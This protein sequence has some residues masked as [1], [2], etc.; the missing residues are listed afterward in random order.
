MEPL[1]ETKSLTKD[2]GSQR[3]IFSLDFTISPGEIVGFVGPNG[4]GKSTTINL[5]A[6]N[7]KPTSGTIKLFGRAVSPESIHAFMPEIG[8]MLSEPTIEN[9]L[10]AHQ[11]FAEAEQLLQKKT[12]WKRLGDLLKLDT[13][14]PV[15]KLSLGNKKKIEI[16]LAL[17]HKPKLVIMDEPTSGIDPLIVT[18]FSALLKEVSERGGAVL[19]SS[20]DLSEVQEVCDRVIMVK[21]GHLILDR[22][23]EQLLKMSN[24]R[25]SV[26]KPSEK[27]TSL[28]TASFGDDVIRTTTGLTLQTRDY[29]RVIKLLSENKTYDF[30]IENPSLEEMFEAYYK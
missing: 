6:G 11:I 26:N 8:L 2:F 16:V 30:L 19:L 9:N 22:P 29:G 17:M 21:E 10:T 15:S 24:R 13:A 20:H 23:V 25:F 4:A 14:K 5:L 7:I 1:V 28:L 27:I 12:E 18:R 3:G